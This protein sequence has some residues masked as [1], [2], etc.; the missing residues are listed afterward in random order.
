M[1][2]IAQHEVVDAFSQLLSRG[3]EVMIHASL[4]PLGHF[5][6]GV[7][8]LIEALCDVVGPEGTVI[9]M[10]DTRSF[11]KTGRF[12]MDQPSETGLLTERFRQTR[13]VV[14]SPTPMASFCALGK[15]AERY[16]AGYNSH[17]DESAPLTRLLEADGKIMLMGIGFDYCTLYHLAEERLEVPYNFHKDFKGVLIENG[18]EKEPVSQ[19]Y[20]VRKSMDTLKSPAA[21]VDLLE[22]E[23]GVKMA[24]L[25]DGLIRAFKARTFD[26]C[27]M[28]ALQADPN[29]FIQKEGN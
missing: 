7:D 19:T 18:V 21:A 23:G 14:R 1:T 27:C 10:T 8:A 25:G 15:R 9:M 2:N 6:A 24:L 3:D 29:A 13:G 5:E 22:A 28:R 20:F 16:A 17:L 4:K 11:A 26:D 12:A